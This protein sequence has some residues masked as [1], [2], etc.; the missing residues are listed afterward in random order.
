MTEQ[1]I[2][3]NILPASN[4]LLKQSYLKMTSIKYLKINSIKYINQKIL[5]NVQTTASC[6]ICVIKFTRSLEHISH[7]LNSVLMDY[8]ITLLSVSKPAKISRLQ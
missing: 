7:M 2:S 3:T 1:S 8:E 5:K 4:H 6:Q